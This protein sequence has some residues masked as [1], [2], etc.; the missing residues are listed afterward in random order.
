MSRA[1]LERIRAELANDPVRAAQGL[2]EAIDEALQVG[3][4]YQTGHYLLITF[5]KYGTKLDS[6]MLGPVGLVEG[7]ALGRAAIQAGEC[8]SAAVT[9]V[10]WNSRDDAW[11]N[12]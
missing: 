6:R 10:A 2:V 7:Q 5:D 4:K 1:L 8:D 12:R 3:G 9:R 11:G